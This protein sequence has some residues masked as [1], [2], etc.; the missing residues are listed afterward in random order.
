MTDKKE[1]NLP[2]TKNRRRRLMIKQNVGVELACPRNLSQKKIR[3]NL[4]KSVCN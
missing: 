2:P 4:S 3:F 1:Q